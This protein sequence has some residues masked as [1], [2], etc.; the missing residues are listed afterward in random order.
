MNW[1]KWN[2]LLHRD[3]GYLCIGLT[4]I[5]AI[6]GIALNHIS[7]GFNPSYSI[8][9]SSGS[10]TPLP[11]GGKPDMHYIQS[12]LKEINEPGAFKNA[13]LI[14]PGT[15][16]IFVEDNTLDIQL[17]TGHVTMERINRR[18]VLYE[19]N[20]LHLNKAKGSWLWLADV[21]G[22]ALCLLAA[23]GLLMIRG[24][25]KRRGILLTAVG[26]L[27]PLFYVVVIQ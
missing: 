27:V 15:I 1:R 22:I 3:I 25:Q 12:V 16:R 26:F 11:A 7:P 6:S 19:V 23:T 13:A 2:Y 9:N 14:S 21:Y 10:V 8:E 17:A 20:Y 5:Y 18:P 4:L 24:K